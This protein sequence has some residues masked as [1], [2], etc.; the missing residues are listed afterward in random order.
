[1]LLICSCFAA[2]TALQ[3]HR[4]Y[5]H[6]LALAES[7]SAAQA[8]SVAGETAKTLDRLSALGIAYVNA[9]DEQSAAQVVSGSEPDRVLNIALADATGRIVSALKGNPLT[10]KPIAA[11]SLKRAFARRSIETYSDPAIGASPFT[12]MFR[13][14]KERPAR[15]IVMVLDPV[16][17]LPNAGGR[18][19]G[20]GETAIFTRAGAAL[21][22]SDGWQNAPPGYLLRDDAAKPSVRY[23]DVGGERRIVALSPVPGWPLSAATSLRAG[24]ALASWYGSLPLYLFVILGPAIAGAALAAI[25][26]HEFER[27]MRARSAAA[28]ATS[29]SG[30]GEAAKTAESPQSESELLARLAI[31]ERRAQESERAKLEFV[32]HMSHELRTP[33]NA[34]IGFAEIIGTG[35][36]GPA[37]NA[38]Y[39][40]YAHDIAA[41]GRSL[42]GRLGE[43]LEFAKL[44]PED[45]AIEM[46]EFD[47]AEVA[48]TC[49]AGCQGVALSRNIVFRQ[50]LSVLPKAKGDARAVKRILTVILSNALRYTPEGGSVSLE[51]R[52]EDETLVLG[53]RDS[54]TGISTDEAERIGTPFARFERAEENGIGLGLA[55]AMALARRMGGA[56]RLEGSLGEGTWAEL[57]LPK[58]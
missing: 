1:V 51:A 25:F 8:A 39:V 18:N 21:A 26:V 4:D 48:R 6:A 50:Q 43:I 19:H 29:E 14:D 24:D 58:A 30:E 37:G 27:G 38:K 12:L 36:F 40:E 13:A 53:V 47:L 22:L 44:S 31:A 55:A 35:L 2:A 23:V 54:G 16:S 7:F 5:T 3:M 28:E 34:V 52:E 42:H 41:A 33:L 15:Y 11:A 57:R 20:F 46:Q 56:L 17:L 9:I 32:A 45:Q 49:A 10:A